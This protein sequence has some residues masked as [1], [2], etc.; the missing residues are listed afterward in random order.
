MNQ[1]DQNVRTMYPVK[2]LTKYLYIIYNATGSVRVCDFSVTSQ[3]VFKLL[4]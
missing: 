3:D 2:S 1:L 4:I